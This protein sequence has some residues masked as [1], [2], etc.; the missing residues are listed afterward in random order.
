MELIAPTAVIVATLLSTAT[1]A[2]NLPNIVFILADDVGRG[3]SSIREINNKKNL[4]LFI[5]FKFNRNNL[6][7]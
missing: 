6:I 1:A 2:A 3:Q 7:K 5:L 4:Y